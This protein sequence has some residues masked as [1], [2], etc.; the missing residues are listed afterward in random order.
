MTTNK[1]H[2]NN[3]HKNTHIVLIYYNF[4]EFSISTNSYVYILHIR[5][6]RVYIWK[7]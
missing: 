5:G 2:Y 3:A 6:A 4:N 1:Y 7:F